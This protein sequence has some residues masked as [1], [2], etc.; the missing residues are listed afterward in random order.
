MFKEVKKYE[1]DNFFAEK[2]L[3][4]IGPRDRERTGSGEVPPGERLTGEEIRKRTAERLARL[5]AGKPPAD[6]VEVPASVRPTHTR[7]DIHTR[8]EEEPAPD[9]AESGEAADKGLKM[10]GKLEAKETLLLQGVHEN[11]YTQY[12]NP[13]FMMHLRM[14]GLSDKV[15]PI[16]DLIMRHPYDFE[17]KPQGGEIL[18]IVKKEP[19]DK[20]SADIAD[21]FLVVMETSEGH[22]SKVRN[23]AF[24]KDL[25]VNDKLPWMANE[26]F[27]RNLVLYNQRWGSEHARYLYAEEYQKWDKAGRPASEWPAIFKNSFE[28]ISDA[29]KDIH[30]AMNIDFP[31]HYVDLVTRRNLTFEQTDPRVAD[32]VARH[33]GQG[34]TYDNITKNGYGPSGM[35]HISVMADPVLPDVYQIYT[36]NFIRNPLRVNGMGYIMRQADDGSWDIDPRY[37]ENV[38]RDYYSKNPEARVDLELADITRMNETEQKNTAN[39][40]TAVRET[41]INALVVRREKVDREMWKGEDEVP[42]SKLQEIAIYLLP[43][44]QQTPHHHAYIKAS[45]DR[46]WLRKGAKSILDTDVPRLDGSRNDYVAGLLGITL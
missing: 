6:R 38:R 23:D 7:A 1:E 31:Q 11:L 10:S 2:R 43:P 46:V 18:H 20:M 33:V 44:H 36:T 15:Y 21:N 8:E 25:K 34:K 30:V 37:K 45:N 9:Y 32:V 42:T 14:E 39:S 13:A 29:M 19:K 27:K 4:F 28:P 26:E 5:R 17:Y 22:I 24:E 12:M 3:I 16:L 41:Q 40:P 35:L